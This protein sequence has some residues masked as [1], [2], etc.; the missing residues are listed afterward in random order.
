MTPGP[1]VLDDD[2]G[3]VGEPLEE[4]DRG[5]VLEVERDVALADVLLG[6]VGGDR[7]PP[8]EREAGHVAFG[9]LD[10]DHVGTQVREHAPAVRP[11]QHPREVEDGDAVERAGTTDGRGHV[12]EVKGRLG[13]LARPP[14]ATLREGGHLGR[15]ALAVPL[16]LGSSVLSLRRAEPAGCRRAS[17]EEVPGGDGPRGRAGHGGGSVSAE[18]AKSADVTVATT[19][20]TSA[21]TVRHHVHDGGGH[22]HHRAEADRGGDPPAVRAGHERRRR[23]GDRRRSR[24]PT[25]TPVRLDFS[26]DEPNGLGDQSRAASWNA[27]TTATLL[28]GAPLSGQYR[29]EISGPIDGPSAGAL[30][31]VAI[32]SLMRGDTLAGRH[33]DDRHH[34]PGRHRRPGRRHPGEDRRRRQGG[35]QAHPHPG[36]PA[37]HAVGGHRRA[38]STWSP[39]AS[40]AASRSPRCDDVYEAYKQ[41]TGKELPKLAGRCRSAARREGLRPPP[42]PDQ[43]RAVPLPGSR[44]G[45]TTR[46]TRR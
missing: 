11:G 42:G 16:D 40:A 44:P 7:V 46:S 37:Q 15:S 1:E 12:R 23:Q 33:H 8:G 2:V 30:K 35:L 41:F 10:L 14:A 6:E 34:Q 21:T 5:R 36:R 31:T 38:S 17:D 39:S 3:T 22:D 4:V 29:F 24:S 28:T 26:E 32:L 45:S 19:A 25:T 43:R 20:K 9:R 18:A 27:V 13:A